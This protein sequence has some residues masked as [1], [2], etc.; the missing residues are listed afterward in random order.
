MISI[1]AKFN[2]SATIELYRMEA[3][4]SD[5]Y[6]K[7]SCVGDAN[8]GSARSDPLESAATLSHVQGLASSQ[9]LTLDSIVTLR[10]GLVVS[11]NDQEIILLDPTKES[12]HSLG[13]TGSGIIRLLDGER[14]GHGVV[15]ALMVIYDIDERT[16]A[17]EVLK[18]LSELRDQQ[19]LST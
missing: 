6:K 19:L 16:C 8:I 9:P 2:V 14:S 5:A 13:S 1:R 10:R 7:E 11:D 12:Y 3:G 4:V 17:E 18:F 15:A